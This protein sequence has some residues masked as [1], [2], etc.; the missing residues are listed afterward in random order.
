MT[1]VNERGAERGMPAQRT[2]IESGA[3]ERLRDS[4][5]RELNL[6]PPFVGGESSGSEI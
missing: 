2:L 4:P 6:D 5:V 3:A 1:T